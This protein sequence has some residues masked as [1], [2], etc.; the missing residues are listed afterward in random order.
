MLILVAIILVDLVL[1]AGTV[2]STHRKPVRA[3]AHI[4][5]RSDGF[6]HAL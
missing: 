3:R 6:P 1:L 5:R 2:W 4:A